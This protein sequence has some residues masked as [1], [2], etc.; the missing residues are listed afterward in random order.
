MR[1]D[2]IQHRNPNRSQGAWSRFPLAS[3]AWVVVCR[4]HRRRRSKAC[5]SIRRHACRLHPYR[6]RC[7]PARSQGDPGCRCQVRLALSSSRSRAAY[8]RRRDLPCRYGRNSRAAVQPDRRSS[9]R[10]RCCICPRLL[11]ISPP[12][13][14]VLGGRHMGEKRA[15]HQCYGHRC[16]GSCL[17]V[18]ILDSIVV[19]LLLAL[20]RG[21]D[22]PTISGRSHQ[23]AHRP[24]GASRHR[25]SAHCRRGGCIRG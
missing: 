13:R 12:M 15:H 4:R 25:A 5:R 8:R 16:R 19:N 17:K 18:Q 6:C 20:M 9:R 10:L 23:P 2:S 3:L 14:H 7:Q 11:H 22:E 21:S 24:G 1:R